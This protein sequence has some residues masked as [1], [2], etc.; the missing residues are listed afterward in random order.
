MNLLVRKASADDD[1][2]I[3]GILNPIIETGVYTAFDTPSA[4]HHSPPQATTTPSSQTQT[5]SQSQEG[6]RAI[7]RNGAWTHTIILTQFGHYVIIGEGP[8]RLIQILG[9]SKEAEERF[10]KIKWF[11]RQFGESRYFRPEVWNGIA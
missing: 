2:V 6:R 1:E 4:F 10:H 5:P 3:V 11:W 9:S 7:L 8:D